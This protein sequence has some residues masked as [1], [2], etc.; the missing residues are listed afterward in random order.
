MNDTDGM[1][2][3]VWDQLYTEDLAPSEDVE[4][5]G[6]DLT[7]FSDY[8]MLESQRIKEAW[9]N[10]LN[11]DPRLRDPLREIDT[12]LGENSHYMQAHIGGEDYLEVSRGEKNAPDP[13]HL[14]IDQT[15]EQ[16]NATGNHFFQNMDERDKLY[17]IKE[18]PIAFEI[19]ELFNETIPLETGTTHLDIHVPTEQSFFT[20]RY[21]RAMEEFDTSTYTDHVQNY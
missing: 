14:R 12:V 18:V 17:N 2:H 19:T 11:T 7:S 16:L 13:L 10:I 5:Y 3:E 8:K 21:T 6:G 1:D 4:I 9:E 20:D 15:P